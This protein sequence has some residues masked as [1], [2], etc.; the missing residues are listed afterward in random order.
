MRIDI[1]LHTIRTRGILR[2]NGETW[3]TPGEL[4]AIMDRVGIDCGILLPLV[5]PEAMHHTM[6]TEEILLAAHDYPG[7]FIPFCNVDPRTD[8]NGPSSDMRRFLEYYVALG[9]KGVGEITANLFMDDPRVQNLF[10][11]CEACHLPATIHVAPQ[12]GGLYGLIDEPGLPRLERTLQRHPGLIILGHSQPFWAEMGPVSPNERNGYPQGP[13]LPGGRLPEL[14]ARCPNLYGDLSAGSGYNAVSRDPEFGYQ[15]L[16]QYQDRLC[17]GTDI[18]SPTTETPLIEFLDAAI[19]QGKISHQ[20]Y[21][22]ITWRNAS[23]LLKL[24]P[25]ASA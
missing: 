8:T 11:A 6:L 3:A 4:V 24:E 21:D 18:C 16:E 7:R 23:A 13:V 2:A 1:H 14:F 25:A 15:F 12:Y 9:C 22:K 19:A 20:A 5:S 17:F 10:A